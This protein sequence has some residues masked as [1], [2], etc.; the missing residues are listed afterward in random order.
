MHVEIDLSGD[1]LLP[2]QRKLLNSKHKKTALICGRGAGKSYA[3]A[4]LVLLTLL[5]GRNVLVGGQRYD[6]I[7]DTLFE[8]IKLLASDWGIYDYIEWR[9]RPMMMTMGESHVWF[10]TYASVEACRG[11]TRVSLIVLDEMFL[12]P[13]NILSIWG[14]CMRSTPD[15]K[16]R[17]VGATTPRG[18][19]LWNVLFSDPNCDWEVIRAVTKDNTHIKEEEYQLILSEIHDEEMYKQ[20]ILGQISSG[21]GA[22]AIIHLEDFP[23][24][25]AP[26]NDTRVLAGLDCGEGVERDCTAFVKRRGNT[27]LEAWEL[28]GINHEETVRKILESNKKIPIDYMAMD[29]AFS[30]YE[31]GILKY[32]FPC[33][34]VNFA[35]SASEDFK[36]KYANIR[37]EM[38]FNTAWTIK[39][40]LYVGDTELAP[41]IKRQLCAMGWFHNN[42]RRLLIT[43]KDQLREVLRCSPDIADALALTCLDRYSGDEPQIQLVKTER[44]RKQMRRYAA[45]MGG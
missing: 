36:E 45:M 31:Y 2:H 19:S 40:G 12:A 7:H 3:C 30:D 13:P 43:P 32:H 5:R 14:P 20:E 38:F 11:Y 26:S 29:A 44:D 41:K 39:N 22:S 23:N 6:T 8:E 15:G 9:E 24:A 1:K 28:N 34:Q 37:A 27:I 16:T 42:Q 35:E 21:L 33:R 10:G 25:P 4:A 17:V 18:G